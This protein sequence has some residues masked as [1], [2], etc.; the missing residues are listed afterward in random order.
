MHKL[1]IELTICANLNFYDTGLASWLLGIRAPGQMAFHAQRG[2]LF[3]NL[4]VSEFLKIRLHQGQPPDLHFWRDSRGLEVDLL[5]EK[6]G[7]LHPLEIKSGQTIGSDFFDAL[8][9]WR[10]LSGS[11]DR[12][13]WLV[14]GGDRPFCHGSVDVVPWRELPELEGRMGTT[15]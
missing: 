9:K 15:G 14:Y 2:P 4:V 6:H 12:P 11:G 10:E 1:I 8:G 13:A 3:E 5:V 7:T